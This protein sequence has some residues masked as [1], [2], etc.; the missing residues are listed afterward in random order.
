MNSLGFLKG[1][2][3]CLHTT[4]PRSMLL[5]HMLL[6]I[7]TVQLNLALKDALKIISH[8]PT[9]HCL[10]VNSVM[11]NNFVTIHQEVLH[12]LKS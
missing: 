2:N 12:L 9:D 7:L 5:H 3:N 1:L 11:T 10:V 8:E 6:E 4:F